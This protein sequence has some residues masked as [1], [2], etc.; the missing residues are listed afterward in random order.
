MTEGI[1]GKNIKLV[2]DRVAFWASSLDAMLQAFVSA[3]NAGDKL[4]T[5]VSAAR[6]AQ[7]GGCLGSEYE[8]ICNGFIDS[9]TE[10][11]VAEQQAAMVVR[12]VEK[13]GED[14]VSPGLAPGEAPDRGLS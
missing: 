9:A 2:T 13:N 1:A 10:Q 4:G 7:L 6:L 12:M 3:V 11:K 14:L 5:I 8:A